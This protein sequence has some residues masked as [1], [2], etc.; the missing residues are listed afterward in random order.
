MPF[1]DSDRAKLRAQL[2]RHEGLRLVP[3]TDT[4]GH[5]TIGVGHLLSRGISYA[6]AEHLLDED[7]AEVLTWLRGR[8]WWIALDPIRQRVIADMVFNLGIDEF[9]AFKDMRAALF[10]GNYDK[11]AAEMLDSRWAKQVG[12]QPGQRAWRL[13]EMMRTG[14]EVA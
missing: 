12:D 4:E 3:Y 7:L 11:A 13:A 2:I 9:H 1:S 5:L 8:P 14:S 6:V 10:R